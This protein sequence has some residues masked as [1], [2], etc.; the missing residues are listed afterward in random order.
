MVNHS[1]DKLFGRYSFHEMVC[2]VVIMVILEGCEK[3]E[4]FFSILDTVLHIAPSPVLQYD[5]S[6]E[7]A[8]DSL[9]FDEDGFYLNDCS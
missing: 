9:P 6:N 4:Q 7:R 1:G 5:V 8:A 3:G 2:K